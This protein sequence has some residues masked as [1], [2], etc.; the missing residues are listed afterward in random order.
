MNSHS[1]RIDH[2]KLLFAS[3]GIFAF[4]YFPLVVMT[5]FSFNQSRLMMDW[6]GF[7]TMWYRILVHDTRLLD[8]LSNS[9]WVAVW[10]TLL[11]LVIG[12]P[13]GVVLSRDAERELKRGKV[14]FDVLI[15][16]PL[17]VPEIVLAVA[18][19]GLYGFARIRLSF[20]TIVVTHVAFSL[21]YVIMLVRARMSRLDYTLVEAAMDLAA[22]ESLVFLRVILPHLT[23]ALIS[24]ALMVF[25]ISLDDYVITSFVAGVGNTTLPLQIY[26]MTKEGLTPEINAVCTVLMIVTVAIVLVTQWVQRSALSWHKTVFSLLL[27][28]SLIGA[29]LGWHQY[30]VSREHRQVL[31]LFIWSAYLAPDT[32]KVFEQRFNARVLFDLYDS[33]EALLAKLESGNAGYDLIV[34]GDYTVQILR[35]R[36]LLSPLDKSQ[37]PNLEKNLYP[38]FLNKQFDPGNQYSVPYMW[39]ITGIGYRKDLVSDPVTSWRDLW[40][41]KYR[42]KIVMLD[43]MRENFGAALKLAGFSINS[44]EPSQVQ[45]AKKLLELQKPLLQAYNSS[46]FQEVLASGDAWLVQGW[47]GQ[48][49]KAAQENPNIVFSVPREGTILFIDSFCI[50]LDAPHKKLAH[51]FVNYMLEPETAAAVVNHTGYTVANRAARPYIRRSLLSDPA[52]FPESGTLNQCEML[53]DLGESVLMYDRFWTEIKSK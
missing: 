50:P 21:S 38:Q 30:S 46:N 48:I 25:I 36:R 33:N 16:L 23:P 45:Q 40:A 2:P 32:L 15:L 52:L 42:N 28:A 13:A 3:L 4:L 39:G 26:S 24:A 5:L 10:T 9:V 53:E 1:R 34:P 27:V 20:V 41:E 49:A 18:F 44:R 22:N 12:V 8:S 43:D 35:R 17:V 31:N 19:A 14:F 11:S 29:P 37:I 47:N 51:Q 7:T 6:Q